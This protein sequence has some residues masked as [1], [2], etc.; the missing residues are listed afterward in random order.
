[1]VKGGSSL[2]LRRGIHDSRTSKDL[3]TVARRDIEEV[4]EQLAEAGEMGWEG[5]TAIFTVP[6]EIDVPGMPCRTIRLSV[7]VI[8]P[9]S[10]STLPHLRPIGPQPCSPPITDS[11]GLGIPRRPRPR[12]C[13]S[14]MVMSRR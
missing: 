3:D 1:L 8:R 6:E 11:D 9:W 4:H 2:E 13:A 5:F 10:R 14:S 7:G 12:L